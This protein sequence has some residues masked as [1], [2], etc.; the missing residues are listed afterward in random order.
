MMSLMISSMS[1][2]DT[3]F[4]VV[5]IYMVLCQVPLYFGIMSFLPPGIFPHIGISPR[6]IAVF[7]PSR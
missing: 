4:I 3:F 5:T 1:G 2:L 7:N 6:R